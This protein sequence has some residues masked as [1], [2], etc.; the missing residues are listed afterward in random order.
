MRLVLFLS[1]I[2]FSIIISIALP[3]FGLL[4]FSWLAYMR[5]QNLVWASESWRFS[6]YISIAIL[7][8]CLLNSSK[9]K[10]FVKAKEN[11]LL[12][13]FWIT[14]LISSFFAIWPDIAFPKFIELSKI[15]FI[16]IVTSG[17]VNSKKRFKNLCWVIALSFAFSAVKGAIRGIFW[18]WQVKGPPDSMIADNNDFALAL[19]MILPFFFYLGMNEKIKSRKLFFYL[20]FF[21]T[22]ITVICT[23]SRGGF[24]GLV[25][26]ILLLVF[27]SKRKKIGFTFLTIGIVLFFNFIPQEYKERIET[28]KS[29]QEDESAMGRIY[30]WQAA[31][32]MA[33]DR[34]LTG[35]GM[36]KENFLLAFPKYHSFKPRVAHNSYLQLLADSGF[37]ALA[38]FLFLLY[39]SIKKL[40]YLRK[41]IIRNETNIWI[42]NYS[43]MLEV[44]LFGYMVTGMFLSRAD[45]DFFYQ[46]IGLTVALQVIANKGKKE[47]IC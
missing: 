35:V 38:I 14:L 34:P 25:A 40:R 11:Y 18:G 31:W 29:Y 19:N 26:V 23:Y 30:A 12:V 1:I 46:L 32:A 24:I 16:A 27:K 45:F 7:I 5:P 9:E 21:I 42:F 4:V 36:G 37:I 6:F 43:H 41:S 28:I 22:I 2:G 17:L 44:S 47:S 8:G 3:F 15:I 13:A 10:F 39:S 33:K 20:L